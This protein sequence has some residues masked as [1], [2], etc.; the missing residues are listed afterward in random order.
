MHWDSQIYISCLH[1]FLLPEPPTSLTDLIG[2][3][4]DVSNLTC[5]NWIS[6]PKPIL[7]S[8]N[9]ISIDGNFIPKVV[10]ANLL[11]MLGLYSFE[12]VI[13]LILSHTSP[14]IQSCYFKTYSKSDH[15]LLYPLR[16]LHLSNH[17]CLSGRM[18]TSL[19][20][21]LC[22]QLFILV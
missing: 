14:S 17:H 18:V 5:K 4:I 8:I 15:F 9:S 7:L 22:P 20:V 6:F 10:Q 3:P 12:V 19:P 13:G 2:C 16:P 11:V 1:L 21:S